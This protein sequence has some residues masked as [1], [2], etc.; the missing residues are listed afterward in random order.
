MIIL[1]N[2]AIIGSNRGIGLALTQ[3]YS[4]EHKVFAFCRK[5]SDE[6]KK[7]ETSGNVKIFEGCDVNSEYSV[8][9][10]ARDLGT[11]Q[12]DLFFHV[13]GILKSEDFETINPA[14][15][16]EQFLT[17]SIAPLISV[18]AFKKNFKRGTKVGLLTSRMGSIADNDSG[19]MYGYRMSKAALNAGGK[20]LAVDLEPQSISVFLLHPGYVQTDMTGGSG[21][22]TTEESA[23]GLAKVMEVN[24]HD[25]TGKFFHS[26]GEE[27][28]W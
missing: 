14:S 20:S 12:I 2:V 11:E 17:N 24:N 10:S 5:Y 3:L 4:K 16:E 1:M 26:N 27:L 6:L 23:A 25:K 22:I 21:H 15:I 18:R 9:N 13:S 8:Q 28:P 7:L 19:G